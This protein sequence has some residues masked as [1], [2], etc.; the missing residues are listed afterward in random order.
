MTGAEEATGASVGVGSDGRVAAGVGTGACVGSVGG[1][2]A[3]TEAG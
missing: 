3:S 1:F 2:E